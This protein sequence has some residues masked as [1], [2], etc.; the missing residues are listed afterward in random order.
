VANA[1]K[2]V[3]F[4]H[5]GDYDRIHQGLSIAA[6]ASSSG[7]EAMVIF[8]WWALHRLA[9]DRLDEIP[10]DLRGCPAEALERLREGNFPTPTALLQTAR[11]GGA[12]VFACTGSLAI[13]GQRP[14]ALEGKVDGF[15]GWA[16]ILEMTKGVAD[17]FYL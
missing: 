7:R 15:V 3:V 5:S 6:A 17:R 10:E 13:L 1:G 12:K 14:D 2:V 16:S 9:G 11:A 8:F 4:L